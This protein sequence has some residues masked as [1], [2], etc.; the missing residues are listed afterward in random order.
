MTLDER[1]AALGL[2]LPETDKPACADAV[3]DVEK[4]AKLLAQTRIHYWEEPAPALDLKRMLQA[5]KR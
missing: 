5:G 4:T 3:A 2:R 1:L